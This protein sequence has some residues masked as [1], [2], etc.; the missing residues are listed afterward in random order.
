LATLQALLLCDYAQTREGLLFVLSGGVD[1][2]R[3]QTLPASLGVHLAGAL[4]LEPDEVGIVHELRFKITCEGRTYVDE[5]IGVQ[6]DHVQ[7]D[8]PGYC[9]MVKFSLPLNAVQV[10]DYGLYDVVV[11]V[12]GREEKRVSFH[13][14]PPPDSPGIDAPSQPAS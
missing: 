11:Y 1:L 7:M 8:I 6:Y 10:E 12:N 14:I 13:V 2:L 3:R 5:V 9:P 4:L